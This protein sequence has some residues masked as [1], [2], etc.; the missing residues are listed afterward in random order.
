M[1]VNA[2]LKKDL[3]RNFEIKQD[4]VERMYSY[5]SPMPDDV[6]RAELQ[7]V[8]LGEQDVPIRVI[9]AIAKVAQRPVSAYLGGE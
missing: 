6:C 3:Q 5:F 8:L 2:E 9:R 4:G 7:A 1:K